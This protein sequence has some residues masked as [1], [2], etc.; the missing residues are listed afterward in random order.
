MPARRMARDEHT[1]QV[2]TV[3]WRQ[4]AQVVE[5]GR[6]VLEGSRIA[7]ARMADAAVF[8]VPDRIAPL[9]QIGGHV[10]HQLESRQVGAPTA[11]VDQDNDR[12]AALSVRNPELA[13]LKGL[14][15]IGDASVGGGARL[16]QKLAEGDGGPG[17]DRGQGR[18]R[19]RAAGRRR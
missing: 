12:M 14:R 16:G 5:A 17:L 6:D 13:E 8:E 10:V 4:R 2:E 11:A 9:A 19:R 15:A 3:F 18:R 1:V 7:A